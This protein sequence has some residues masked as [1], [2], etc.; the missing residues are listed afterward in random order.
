VPDASYILYDIQG[1]KGA[2][3]LYGPVQSIRYS[4]QLGESSALQSYNSYDIQGKK[5]G[6][7]SY[8]LYNSYDIQH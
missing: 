7:V 8:D 2:V 6:L 1:K 5:G 4:T 3:V